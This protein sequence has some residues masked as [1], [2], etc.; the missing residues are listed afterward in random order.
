MVIMTVKIFRN[1]VIKNLVWFVLLGMI[2]LIISSEVFTGVISTY[3]EVAYQRQLERLVACLDEPHLLYC[4]QELSD[5]NKQA[6]TLSPEL[7]E[8]LR[9]AHGSLACL[10]F[11]DLVNK[12]DNQETLEVRLT[13][14]LI[15]WAEKNNYI[16]SGH[17][18]NYLKQPK[19]FELAL[20][21][22]F[23]YHTETSADGMFKT[24]KKS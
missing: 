15:N 10:I 9:H 23:I 2:L 1:R 12:S 18:Q 3:K 14:L 22:N 4:V 8:K 17:K 21:K 20:K 11:L 19:D 6:V 13:R 16:E 7:R 24:N 5:L